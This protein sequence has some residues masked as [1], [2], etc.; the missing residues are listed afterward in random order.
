L[1]QLQSTR[2][3][4]ATLRSELFE[5]FLSIGIHEKERCELLR[6]MFDLEAQQTK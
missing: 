3:Y 5:R 2:I 4:T 6:S 1:L